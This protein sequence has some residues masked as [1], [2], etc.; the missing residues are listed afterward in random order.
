MKYL[1]DTCV[2]SEVVKKQP[3]IKVISWLNEQ[4]ENN[5]YLSVLTFGEIAK[6]INKLTDQSRKRK[7][8]LWLDED[9]KSRFKNRIIAIDLAVSIQWGI[10]QGMAEQQGKPM[11]AIDGLIAV[12]GLVNHCIIVTRNIKDMQQS[13]AELYNPW[14]L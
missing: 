8:Q 1:L 11:P 7:L 4:D 10:L 6:G 5:F 13:S 9:L 2:I 14:E 3:N 12:S